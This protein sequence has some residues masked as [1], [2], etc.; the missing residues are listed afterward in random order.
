MAEAS[1]PRY[2]ARRIPYDQAPQDAQP[3]EKRAAAHLDYSVDLSPVLESEELVNAAYAWSSDPTGLPVSWCFFADKGALFYVGGGTDG[4]TYI[5]NLHVRTNFGRAFQ[6]RIELSIE[7]EPEEADADFIPPGMGNPFVPT[8]H[9]I[10]NVLDQLVQ[11][12]PVDG[13][14]NPTDPSNYFIIDA[15]NVLIEPDYLDVL[16]VSLFLDS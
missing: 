12:Y 6:F 2:R 5:A 1:F 15:L 11:E 4:Q 7:G 3:F 14:G 8:I 9:I 13:F 10:N 16:N